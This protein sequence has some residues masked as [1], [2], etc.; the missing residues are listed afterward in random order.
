MVPKSEAAHRN[1]N[2]QYTCRGGP[3]K[4]KADD[5]EKM[6]FKAVQNHTLSPFEAADISPTSDQNESQ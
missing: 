6:R 2:I 1:R 5:G 4:H 3:N